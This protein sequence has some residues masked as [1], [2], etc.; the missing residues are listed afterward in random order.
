M[1]NVH[2]SNGSASINRER[3]LVS[4]SLEIPLSQEQHL[5]PGIKYLLVIRA[6][7]TPHVMESTSSFFSGV[8]RDEI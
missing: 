1:K 2:G 6:A 3:K 7:H 4:G 8:R 5:Y